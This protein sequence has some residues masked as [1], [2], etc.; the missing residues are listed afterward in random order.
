[1]HREGPRLRV[2]QEYGEP[3]HHI[4]HMVTEELERVTIATK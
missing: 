4:K 2:E 1:M 3:H